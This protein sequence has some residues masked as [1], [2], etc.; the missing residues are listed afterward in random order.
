[1]EIINKEQPARASLL[2]WWSNGYQ[3]GRPIGRATWRQNRGTSVDSI[4]MAEDVNA[5]MVLAKLTSR[6]P[7]RCFGNL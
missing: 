2:N 4:D 1:M 5:L 3:F 6:S 7:S